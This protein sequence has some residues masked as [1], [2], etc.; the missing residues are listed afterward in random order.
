MAGQIFTFH[1]NVVNINIEKFIVAPSTLHPPTKNITKQINGISKI[2]VF[3]LVWVSQLEGVGV[4]VVEVV[5]RSKLFLMRG[6]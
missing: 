1:Y 6:P 3:H 2:N 5:V 4:V